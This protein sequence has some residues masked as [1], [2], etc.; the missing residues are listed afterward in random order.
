MGSAKGLDDLRS[1]F[2]FPQH[3]QILHGQTAH[4][5]PCGHS[6]SRPLASREVGDGLFALEF[7]MALKDGPVCKRCGGARWSKVGVCKDCAREYSRNYNLSKKTGEKMEPV[8]LNRQIPRV[9]K[10]KSQLALEREREH[11]RGAARERRKLPINQ[12]KEREWKRAYR[13][14]N[15]EKDA[16]RNHRRLACI[17]ENGGI[18]T[19][20]DW[21]A[22]KKAQG[23]CCLAC[24]KKA[25]LTVDHI[26]PLSKGGRNEPANVQG[27]CKSCNSSKGNRHNTDYRPKPPVKE[28]SL[29]LIQRIKKLLG[30]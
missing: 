2:L 12:E 18:L 7:N 1:A 24:G 30:Y 23:G 16:E 8:P 26:I 25:R 9:K 28:G 22:I 17:R 27:L 29:N 5:L 11:R 4:H 10:P 21:K 6:P 15:P 14:A 13:R 19:A 3:N 20:G